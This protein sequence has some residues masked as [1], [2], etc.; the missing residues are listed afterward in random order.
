MKQLILNRKIQK[1]FGWIFKAFEVILVIRAIIL[2]LSYS[3]SNR[4]IRKLLLLAFFCSGIFMLV[5]ELLYFFG[6]THLLTFVET[7]ILSIL[8]FCLFLG[9]RTK[10]PDEKP[11][12]FA[13]KIN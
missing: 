12:Q 1:A 10:F 7:Q 4:Q 11:V 9:L 8:L 6:K 3:L 2:L 13:N 5:H